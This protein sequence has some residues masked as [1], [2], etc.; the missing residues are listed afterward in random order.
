MLGLDFALMVISAVRY[1]TPYSIASKHARACD[2]NGAGGTA[3]SLSILI[4]N[5]K[6]NPYWAERKTSFKNSMQVIL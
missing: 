1:D 6:N 5:P 4:N 2:V 3:C